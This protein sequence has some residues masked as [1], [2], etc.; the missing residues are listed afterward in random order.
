MKISINHA[1]EF[2]EQY[3]LASGVTLAEQDVLRCL[4]HVFAETVPA[5]PEPQSLRLTE[6]SIRKMIEQYITKPIQSPPY[7]VVAYMCSF[8]GSSYP[9]QGAY[10][11]GF[12]NVTAETDHNVVIVNKTDKE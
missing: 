8:P 12:T 9:N 3:K 5:T 7:S 11:A 6:E 4:E 10:T 2:V 1:K